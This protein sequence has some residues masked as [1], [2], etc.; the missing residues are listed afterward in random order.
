MKTFL[1]VSAIAL[2]IMLAACGDETAAN[3]GAATGDAE[4]DTSQNWIEVV[5]KTEEGGFQMGNPDAPIKIVEFASMTCDHCATFAKESFEPL[6]ENY[7]LQGLVSF[8]VRNFVRDPLDLSAALLARCNGEG[9]FF[10]LNE[11][12]FSYQGQM[13]E[14][15]QSADQ[16]QLRALQAPET[17]QNGQTFIGFAEAAGLIDLVGGLGVSD[18]RARQC[19]TDSM[20]IGELVEMRNRALNQHNISGTPSFL[21]NGELVGGVS[22]WSQLDARL[23]EIFQ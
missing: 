21:I 4:V 12:L 10:P 7:I 1:K 16:A 13:L 5:T 23:Q 8:E 14:A 15:I 3:S 2:G 22:S 19:L 17:R 6:T 11:R 20:A 18:Q 9:P